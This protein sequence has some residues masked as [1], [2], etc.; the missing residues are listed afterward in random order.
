MEIIMKRVL[1]QGAVFALLALPLLATM[2]ASA[3]GEG[4][5]CG[6][7]TQ[8]ECDAGLFCEYPEGCKSSAGVCETIPDVC[9]FSEADSEAIVEVCGCDKKNYSSDCERKKAGAQKDHDGACKK[10]E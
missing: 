7:F 3:A 8:V 10:A 5:L 1:F 6:G 2:P 4:E 9:P